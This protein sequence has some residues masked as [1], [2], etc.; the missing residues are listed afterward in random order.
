MVVVVAPGNEV[1]LLSLATKPTDIHAVPRLLG[2]M[3][4]E[5]HV[6][7]GGR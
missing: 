5:A 1:D 7:L 3:V 4:T 6:V 2:D